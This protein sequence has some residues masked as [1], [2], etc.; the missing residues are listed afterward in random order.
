MDSFWSKGFLTIAIPLFLLCPLVQGEVVSQNCE[1][2]NVSNTFVLDCYAPSVFMKDQAGVWRNFSDVVSVKWDPLT[3]SYKVSWNKKSFEITPFVVLNGRKTYLNKV[4][5]DVLRRLNFNPL[6]KGSP[7]SYKFSFDLSMVAGLSSIGFDVNSSQ[8][9]SQADVAQSFFKWADLGI[10]LSDLKDSGFSLVQSPSGNNLEVRTAGLLSS[11]LINFDPEIS[12]TPFVN[13]RFADTCTTTLPPDP[14]TSCVLRVTFRSYE[15][16][17][18][19]VPLS[20]QTIEWRSIIGFQNIPL[21]SNFIIEKVEVSAYTSVNGLPGSQV[22]QYKKVLHAGSDGAL[23]YSIYSGFLYVEKGHAYFLINQY[24]PWVD[25]GSQAI[26][27]LYSHPKYFDLGQKV[28]ETALFSDESW[29]G[30]ITWRP[31]DSGSPAVLRITYKVMSP[32]LPGFKKSKPFD[33]D[34]WLAYALMS[35]ALLIAMVYVFRRKKRREDDQE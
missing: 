22:I 29:D 28:R 18:D 21:E 24:Y 16:R 6:I 14:I 26:N 10:S 4:P 8:P 19:S 9:L 31:Q 15:N 5:A 23:Y 20:R 12:Q 27:D 34:S 1:Q 13:Y 33:L 30:L 25:L 32:V 11:G 2:H 35:S 17:W 7:G 3:Y